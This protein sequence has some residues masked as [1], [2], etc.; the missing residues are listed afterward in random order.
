MAGVQAGFRVTGH[1][2]VARAL[3]SL[4]VEVDDLKA[5][6]AALAAE[7]AQVAARHAPRRTGRLAG[8]IRGTRARSAAVVTASVPYAGAINYGW[9]RRGIAAAG[10][11]QAADSAPRAV[12]ALEAEINRAIARK[13]L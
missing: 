10:F 8:S 5:A 9:P 11:M 3:R 13:G 4:G 12:A 7:G 1:A 2:E 6:F